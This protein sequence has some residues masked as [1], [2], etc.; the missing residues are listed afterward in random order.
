MNSDAVKGILF[1][2]RYWIQIKRPGYWRSFFWEVNGRI[3]E[4][5]CE[6]C[7]CGVVG[8]PENGSPGIPKFIELVFN[9]VDGTESMKDLPSISNGSSH[10]LSLSKCDNF[11]GTAFVNISFAYVASIINNP[12]LLSS[13]P[14]SLSVSN[15]NKLMFK[16]HGKIP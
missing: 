16:A 3:W 13:S 8:K 5:L 1:L 4:I 6:A 2:F 11:P 7:N 14:N 10:R 15:Q 9:G 12:P